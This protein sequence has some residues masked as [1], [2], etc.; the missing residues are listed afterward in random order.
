MSR[1]KVWFTVFGSLLLASIVVLVIRAYWPPGGNAVGEIQ[2]LESGPYDPGKAIILSLPVESRGV[3]LYKWTSPDGGKFTS[4]SEGP[5]VRFEVPSSGPVRV[6]CAVTVNGVKVEKT[7]PVQ[8]KGSGPSSNLP[9][10]SAVETPAVEDLGEILAGLKLGRGLGM[11]VDTSEKR[12]DWV[13]PTEEK[14]ALTL[15]YPGDPVFGAVF[16]TVGK[17]RDGDRPG[18]DY[19][20]FKDLEIEMKGER[21]GESLDIGIK[22]LSQPD[23]GL[24][25]RIP[26]QLTRS[27]QTYQLPVTKFS[28]TDVRRLYVV[29]E[30]VFDVKPETIYVRR[31]RYVK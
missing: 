25:T 22:D 5:S 29:C 2:V 18:R 9:A 20:A 23:D 11:G 4:T 13:K 6:I 14:D 3:V 21:G 26:V 12:H 10:P 27:W 8:V 17:P 19:S 24:E 30:F 16:I 15:A 1:T 31:I 7:F 28:G